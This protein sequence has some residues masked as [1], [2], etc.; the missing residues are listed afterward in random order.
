MD[1]LITTPRSFITLRPAQEADAQSFRDMRPEAL[2]N[3]PDVFSADYAVNY[4]QP[5]TFWEGRLRSLGSEGMIYF[6]AHEDELIVLPKILP[7][8]FTPA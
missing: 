3:H 1:T 4:G 7:R 8:W 2:R 5:F 6:A